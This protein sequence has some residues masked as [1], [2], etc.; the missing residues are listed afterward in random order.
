MSMFLTL[1]MMVISQLFIQITLT[2]QLKRFIII[3]FSTRLNQI[4]KW[5]F[6]LEQLE[7]LTEELGVELLL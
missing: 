2:T 5:I 7:I 1:L 4:V 3:C 6:V